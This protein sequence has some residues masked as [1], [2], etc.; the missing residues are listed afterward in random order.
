MT[1]ATAYRPAILFSVHQQSDRS[2]NSR[3]TRVTKPLPPAVI[4][5]IFLH[6][7]QVAT[8]KIVINQHP[9]HFPFSVT[10]YTMLAWQAEKNLSGKT[11]TL[12]VA[13]QCMG[14]DQKRYRLERVSC[15]QT[16]KKISL[17]N[18]ACRHQNIINMIPCFLLLSPIPFFILS[19]SHR[20]RSQETFFSTGIYRRSQ[21]DIPALFCSLKYSI[22]T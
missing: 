10:R 8:E 9:V 2:A 1:G 4:Q 7:K 21:T 14:K 11:G 5:Q 12:C 6:S 13:P 19:G 22:R 18:S 3:Q 17:A 16:A 15:Y 20:Y